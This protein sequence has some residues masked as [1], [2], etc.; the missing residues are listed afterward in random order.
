MVNY[1]EATVNKRTN[2][3]IIKQIK[4][5][6][7]TKTRPTTKIRNAFANNMSTDVKLSKIQ[8]SKII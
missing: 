2:K 3:Y 5:Y 4:V 1:Q 7:K 8:I 6:I